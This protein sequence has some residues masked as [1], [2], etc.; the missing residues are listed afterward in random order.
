MD[1]AQ[2]QENIFALSQKVESLALSLGRRSMSAD[3][4]RLLV[5]NMDQPSSARIDAVVVLCDA[6]SRK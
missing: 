5:S 6:E 4:L 2:P 3:V 1:D